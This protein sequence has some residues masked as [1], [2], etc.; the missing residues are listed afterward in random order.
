MR[1]LAVAQKLEGEE[2]RAAGLSG[3]LHDVGRFEQYTRYGTFVDAKSVNHAELGVHVLMEAGLLDRFTKPVW[4]RILDA[5]RLHNRAAVPEGLSEEGLQ[6]ACMLRDADKLDIWHIVTAHYE[7]PDKGR[8]SAI[9]LD[10]SDSDWIIP[11]VAYAAERCALCDVKELRCINDFKV[12]QMTWIYDVNFTPTFREIARR[13][14]MERIRDALPR[15]ALVESIYR[16]VRRHLDE[17]LHH[18]PGA[19]ENP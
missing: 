18:Q 4:A 10:L 15:T 14:F 11:A 17:K 12:L 13:R 2:V 16:R 5:V 9:D 6:L 1:K 7:S 8:I 19:G 3:L